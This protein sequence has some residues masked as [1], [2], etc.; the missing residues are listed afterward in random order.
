[1]E[2]FTRFFR[3]KPD[4]TLRVTTNED[5]TVDLEITG[6]EIPE[7]FI[8]QIHDTIKRL[9]ANPIEEDWMLLIANLI[10]SYD[11]MIFSKALRDHRI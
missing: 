11:N 5:G 7:S 3:L 10:E 8:K 1:M 2:K 4:D 9:D 6:H